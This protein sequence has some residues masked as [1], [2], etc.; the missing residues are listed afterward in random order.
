MVA[1]NRA[2]DIELDGLVPGDMGANRV[3][4]TQFD[5]LAVIDLTI[6]APYVRDIE[7]DALV[8]DTEAGLPRV[9]QLDVL[10]VYGV[11]ERENI[12]TRAWGFV[13]DGHTF[14]VLHLGELGTFVCDLSTGLWA[15]FQTEGM[16]MWNAE[17][18]LM[19]QGMVV[20]GDNQ[21]P[22]LW[23]FD[24]DGQLDDDF[25]PI[26][27]RA[28]GIYAV[29]SR[30]YVTFDLLSITASQDTPAASPATLS[31]TYSDDDGKTFHTADPVFTIVS[32][33]DPQ[34]YQW[35]SLGSA[36]QPGRIFNIEDVGGMVRLSSCELTIRGSRNAE[37]V[38]G[39]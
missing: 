18:G 8:P 2:R 17:A 19:W 10:A 4:D 12:T 29:R 38:N 14:Y 23:N 20:A 24:P 39:S 37:P 11:G 26:R 15:Q 7:L 9:S 31:L 22:T 32:D 27:H 1:S 30:D 6:A 33:G 16:S 5:A 21:N 28:T 3:R 34:D 36:N 25:K 35:S 13:F